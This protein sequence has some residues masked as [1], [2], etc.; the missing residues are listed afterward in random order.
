[1]GRR[2]RDTSTRVSA[3]MVARNAESTIERAIRTALFGLTKDS[4]LLVLLDDCSD[5]SG[6]LA[7]GIRDNRLRIFEV[8][9]NLGVAAG[10]NFLIERATH[11]IIAI[12]DSDDVF[13]PWR[14][15]SGAKGIIAQ[16]LDFH[17]QNAVIFGKNGTV[18][19]FVPQIPDRIKAEDAKV[20]LAHANPFVHSSA[21]FLKSSFNSLGGYRNRPS[22]DYDLWLRASQASMALAKSR[23]WG[24]GYRIHNSQLTQNSNWRAQVKN[25]DELSQ[26]IARQRA[27]VET[28]QNVTPRNRRNWLRKM[29]T[30]VANQLGL[31][32]ISAGRRRD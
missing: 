18:A 5:S 8:K 26:L 16:R 15:V 2:A 21:T 20:A 14:F 25:D 17:F 3:I 23:F 13:F 32:T 11:E 10:R 9:S 30:W 27:M 19:F 28:L 1:M 24:I 29:A 6:D 7:R 22:E 31:Q 4:E 12:C